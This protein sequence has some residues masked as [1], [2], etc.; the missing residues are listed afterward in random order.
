MLEFELKSEHIELVKLLKVMGFAPTG[1][2]AKIMIENGGIIRNGEQEL[3]KRA[4][5]LVGDVIE[6]EGEKIIIK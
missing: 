3:R 6:V 5:L 4:K 1:G 2:H